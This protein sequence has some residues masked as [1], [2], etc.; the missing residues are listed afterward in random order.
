M[1]K[2]NIYIYVSI[3]QMANFLNYNLTVRNKMAVG[4]IRWWRRR[5]NFQNGGTAELPVTRPRV[6]CFPITSVQTTTPRAPKLH[7]IQPVTFHNSI[8]PKYR[9]GNVVPYNNDSTNIQD[10]LT[11]N[12]C[13]GRVK[14][15]ALKGRKLFYMCL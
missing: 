1:H 7:K 9:T 8:Q 3:C 2:K 15:K 4:N 10:K 5:G 12:I 14:E 6:T 13:S 11:K